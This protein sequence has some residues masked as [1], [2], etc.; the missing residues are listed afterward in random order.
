MIDTVVVSERLARDVELLSLL[1]QGEDDGAVRL[2]ET[3]LDRSV[4]S[5]GDVSIAELSPIALNALLKARST[6]KRFLPMLWCWRAV[7]WDC[8]RRFEEMGKS[9]QVRLSPVICG[10]FSVVMQLRAR[11]LQA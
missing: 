8:T 10:S 2:L 3:G 6:E 11:T 7:E 5:L 1:R 4:V 9:R